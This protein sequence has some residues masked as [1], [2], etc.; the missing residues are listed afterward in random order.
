MR[1]YHLALIQATMLEF[2]F[3]LTGKESWKAPN[4]KQ[5]KKRLSLLNLK[6]PLL[7]EKAF[8][9]AK[10]KLM[11]LVIGVRQRFWHEMILSQL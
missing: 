4:Q 7:Q 9:G 11:R 5:A 2:T 1:P 8:D 10:W 6:T 3:K